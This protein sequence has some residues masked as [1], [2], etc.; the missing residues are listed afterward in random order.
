M[1]GCVWGGEGREERESVCMCEG[2]A[3]REPNRTL[4][5][6]HPSKKLKVTPIRNMWICRVL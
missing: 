2:S 1:G 3:E 6:P 5:D 4:Y